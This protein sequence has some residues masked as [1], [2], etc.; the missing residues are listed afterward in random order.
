M[1]IAFVG[2]SG[3]GNT[4]DDTY[5]LVFSRFLPEHQLLFYNSDDPGELPGDIGMV[6][7]GGGGLLYNNPDGA[8]E[9]APSEHFQRMSFYLDW[10]ISRDVPYGILSCGFQFRPG[11]ERNFARPLQP[12]RDYLQQAEFITLRSPNCLRMA[13]ELSGRQDVRFYPDAGFLFEPDEADMLPVRDM[14]TLVPAGPVRPEDPHTERWIR[15]C[16][17]MGY[18]IVWLSMGAAVDDEPLLAWAREVHPASRILEQPT[19]AQAFRQI[20]A[21]RVVLSGRYHGMVFARASKVPFYIP[22]DVPYKLLHE[23]YAAAPYGAMGHIRALQEAIAA[24]HTSA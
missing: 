12:W 23:D 9:S 7:L 13:R 22:E 4:G 1:K 14:L 3:Y 5:P 17:S 21:S 10:A 18:D 15:Y 24:L 20:A 2:A 16:Q 8:D 19:P 6:V 11:Q